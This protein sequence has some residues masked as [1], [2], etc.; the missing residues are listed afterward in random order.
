MEKPEFKPPSR[1]PDQGNVEFHEYS[2]R[3]RPGMDLVLK[4][5]NCDFLPSEKVKFSP[6]TLKNL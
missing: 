1:W 4:D 5:L 6:V 2:T 3:Y